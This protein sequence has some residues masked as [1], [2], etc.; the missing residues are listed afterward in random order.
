MNGS[1]KQLAGMLVYMVSTVLFFT[2]FS[3]DRPSDNL[4]GTTS[5][6]E[7]VF[8]LNN[9][10]IPIDNSGHIGFLNSDTET[11]AYFQGKRVLSQ[12]GFL[13]SGLDAGQMW[14]GGIYSAER[15]NQFVPGKVGSQPLDPKNKI[16]ILQKTDIPFGK[17][18]QEWKN[19]VELGA[20]FYDGDGDGIYSPVDKNGD[21][22][23]NTD[24]DHPDLLGDI[25]AW[26]VFND[27][28]NIG[29][30]KFPQIPAKGIEIHQTAFAYFNNSALSDNVFM[31]YKIINTGT[32]AEQFDSVYF[33]NISNFDISTGF[34][35]Y[36]GC[37]TVLSASY[38]YKRTNGIIFG[39]TEP[40]GYVSFLQG[41]AVYLP[42][43]TFLDKNLNGIFDEGDEPLSFA[44]NRRGERMGIDTVPGAK[45]LRM[46][47]FVQHLS[48][49]PHLP[50]SVISAREKQKGNF[51][52]ESALDPCQ[53]NA[54][55]GSLFPA[56]CS[57]WNPAFMYSGDPVSG[58]GWY[59]T[60]SNDQKSI[61]SAGPFYLEK[62]KPV[63]IYIVI[64][65]ARDYTSSLKSVTRAK[66][67][68]SK[69]HEVFDRNF[70]LEK[71]APIPDIITSSE[72]KSF[73][74]YWN[75]ADF[76]NFKEYNPFLGRDIRPQ[77]YR[78]YFYKTFNP[79]EEIA[80][81]QN[82][83]LWKTIG[84]KNI[85]LS[86]ERRSTVAGNAVVWPFLPAEN[87][88]DTMVYSDAQ[89]GRLGFTVSAD[90]FTGKPLING[91]EYF[92]SIN[93]I[94]LNHE[95]LYEK[96]GAQYGTAGVYIDT[97]GT[98]LMEL[99]SP[100][101]RAVVA[102]DLYRPTPPIVIA[103]SDYNKAPGNIRVLTV[104]PEKLSGDSYKVTF[105]SDTSGEYY[106]AYYTLTNNTTGEVLTNRSDYYI[107]DTTNFSGKITDGFLLR[108]KQSQPS[109]GSFRYQVY[110][111]AE[112]KWF[113]DLGTSFNG[114]GAEYAGSDLTLNVKLSGFIN[115]LSTVTKATSLKRIEIRFGLPGKALR[116][117]NGFSGET[118]P[119]RRSSYIYA[120]GVK[121]E[122]TLQSAGGGI[123]KFGSGWVDVQFQVWAVDSVLGIQSR[124]TPGFVE[125]SSKLIG[126]NPDGEWFPGTDVGRSKEAIIIFD[127]D[128]NEEG[129][130][131]EY[132]GGIF[133]SD[134]AWADLGGYQLPVDIPFTEKQR[135]IA[136]SPL[137]NAIY[138]VRFNALSPDSKPTPGDVFEIPVVTYPY[139]EGESY[140]FTTTAG[141][142][143]DQGD[144]SDL[145]KM[146]NVFPNPLFAYNTSST[147]MRNAGPANAFVTFSNLPE[148]VDIKIYSL[149]GLLIKSLNEA[150]KQDGPG[151]SY[152]RWNLTNHHG[153]K[154]ASGM[155]LA[156]ISSPGLGEKILKFGV[157]LPK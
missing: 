84:V 19:A 156:Y 110:K 41:P 157:I 94:L 72:D 7:Y 35:E 25:T 39:E 64:G 46:T 14:V 44:E 92:F 63:E 32:I 150:D 108:I 86:L 56:E 109:F 67:N 107:D 88:L 154:V 48:E 98:A 38:C 91:K 126:G 57:H 149:A 26:C 104:E 145:F 50:L 55:S 155:Y 30:R 124:L 132:T 141:G 82:K 127:A 21:G 13:L 29:T 5:G 9:L 90:P 95:H 1:I 85:I 23:W 42:G 2:G 47:S 52:P 8:R 10:T 116:Y 119:E 69:I 22:Q 89:T 106:K 73:R 40:A 16:Y 17:S 18:W 81:R 71:T 134:T 77:G 49:A 12:A 129:F 102:D 153:Q 117:L 79:S 87:L 152:L 4:S 83:I 76:I 103:K 142:K 123:G 20:D 43:E 62:N 61:T 118:E 148:R 125:V 137:F 51:Y 60:F 36:V 151:S 93:P 6:K 68:L 136:A 139:Y 70:P 101:L 115:K 112:N 131:P 138:V 143:I 99:E 53:F 28:Q 144:K 15:F 105:E 114:R 80:G 100:L 113:Q 111:P 133:G 3:G 122:D 37:D 65:A 121:G 96:S 34:E 78:I 45:N 31:R 33:S 135:K 97:L 66:E 75:T 24:E 120:A 130:Y 59:N 146:V 128:Y 54:G 58:T 27:G 140:T 74:F 11:G 147:T